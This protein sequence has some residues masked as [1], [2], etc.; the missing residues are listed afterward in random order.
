[1]SVTSTGFDGG[2]GVDPYFTL[3]AGT[4]ATAGMAPFVDP[5]DAQATSTGGDFAWT[6]TLAASRYEIARGD[7][8]NMS[9]AQQQPDLSTLQD[10]FIGIGEPGSPGNPDSSAFGS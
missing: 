4:L 9:F 10:G 8:E 7:F 6:G 3:F 2:N 1:M 5:N